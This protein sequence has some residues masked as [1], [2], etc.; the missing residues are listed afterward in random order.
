MDL[1]INNLPEE[2]TTTVYPR[3]NTEYGYVHLSVC[4][5][6]GGPDYVSLCEPV[7]FTFKIKNK[8]EITTDLVASLKAESSRIRAEAEVACQDID[9][10]IQS[11]LALPDISLAKEA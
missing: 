11:L 7:D 6:G 3:L 4:K 2:V 8:K 9:N 10:K 1:D 5:E